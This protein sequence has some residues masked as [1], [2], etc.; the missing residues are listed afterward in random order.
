MEV[1]R[2]QRNGDVLVITIDHPPVNALNVDVRRGVVDA[3]DAAERD[4]AVAAVLLLGAGRAFSAGADIK[5]FGGPAQPPVLRDTCNRIESCR[6]PVVAVV[7]GNA[8]GGGMEI[9]LSAHYR[10]ALAGAKLGLP[11]VALGLLPGAGGTQRAPRLMG[12][13]PA[14]E[15]MLSGKPLGANEALALGLVDK[16]DTATD[17]LAAGLSFANELVATRAPVRRTRDARKQLDD[18]EN[19]RAALAAARAETARKSR[20]L[21]SPLKIID[22]VE[23]TLDLPFDDGL[24][25]ERELSAQCHASSQRQGLVHAFLAEREVAKAPETRAAKPRSIASAGIIGGGTM[26]AG[27]A[28]A[29]WRPRSRRC[30]GTRCWSRARHPACIRRRAART[31]PS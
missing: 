10:V 4:D 19:T 20:G 13:I 21:F 26:G 31:P 23:A 5:E 15:I 6:K 16:V 14:M 12:A 29:R 9:A 30:R 17:P 18:T 2:T 1:V 25:L 3:I 27:I 24:L 22:A 7:Q 28:V 8:L 11:E